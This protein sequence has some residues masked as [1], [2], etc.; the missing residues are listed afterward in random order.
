MDLTAMAD[1]ISGT[2]NLC[3]I[4]TSHRH[5]VRYTEQL[6][7]ASLSHFNSCEHLSSQRQNTGYITSKLL[8]ILPCFFF[9]TLKL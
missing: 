5:G 8:P 9:F 4:P 7:T 3:D 1:N 6:I 2:R